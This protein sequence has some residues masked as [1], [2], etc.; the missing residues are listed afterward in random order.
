MQCACRNL[1]ETRKLNSCFFGASKVVNEIR[2][3]IS[4]SLENLLE[5]TG[6]NEVHRSRYT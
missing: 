3:K 4:A 2:K 6:V 1:A 5:L